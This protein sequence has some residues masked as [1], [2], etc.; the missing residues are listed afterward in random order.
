LDAPRNGI[1]VV[2]VEEA[3][4][5]DRMNL[6]ARGKVKLERHLTFSNDVEDLVRAQSFEIQLGRDS[7]GASS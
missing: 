1:R 3:G 7:T 5:K 4:V 6:H 2:G